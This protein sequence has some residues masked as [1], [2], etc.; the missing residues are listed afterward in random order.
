MEGLQPL[1]HEIKKIREEG[2]DIGGNTNDTQK[3]TKN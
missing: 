3:K 1:I 2:E